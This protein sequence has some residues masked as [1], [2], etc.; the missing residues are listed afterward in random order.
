VVHGALHLMGY[1]DHTPAGRARMRRRENRVLASLA[2][3][4]AQAPGRSEANRAARK[5]HVAAARGRNRMES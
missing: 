1:D 3:G 4:D 5:N 2:C